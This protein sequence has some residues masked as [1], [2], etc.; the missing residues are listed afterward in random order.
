MQ[1][2]T[3][4]LAF[5]PELLARTTIESHLP[6]FQGFLIGLLVH[7]SQHQDR[8]GIGILHDGRYQSVHFV[9]IKHHYKLKIEN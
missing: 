4:L 3:A 2:V 9:K 7:E 5:R 1:E 6:R 8:L